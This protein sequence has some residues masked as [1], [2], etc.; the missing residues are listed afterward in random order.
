[1]VALKELRKQNN[2]SQDELAK[3]VG[4]GQPAVAMWESGRTVPSMRHVIK[5]CTVLKCSAD[6]IIN[7]EQ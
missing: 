1:M 4:V 6:Q 7:L 3:M 2:L 5:L